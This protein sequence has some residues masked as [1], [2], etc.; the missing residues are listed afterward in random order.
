M[1]VW[2]VVIGS[3]RGVHVI[4]GQ[5]EDFIYYFYL[6]IFVSCYFC[7]VLFSLLVVLRFFF[8]SCS[9]FLNSH[10]LLE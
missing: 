9:V 7:F 8:F 4:V 3:V 5:V 10:C 1:L 6:F 2:G